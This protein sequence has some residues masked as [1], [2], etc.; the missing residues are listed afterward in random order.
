[1]IIRQGMCLNNTYTLIEEI[2]SGGGGIVYKAYHERL[3]TYVVVKR[4]KKQ[5]KGVL[6]NRAE[7][8]ILKNIKHTYLP[9]VYDFLQLD[10][11]IYT[12]MDYIPGRS[13]DKVLAETRAFPQK[14]A[15]KWMTQ[16]AEALAYLHARKPPVI[17]S[18]IKPAN[19][20]LTPEGNVCL[21]DFNVSLVFDHSIRTSTGI[22]GGYSPPEQYPDF[23]EYQKRA[24]SNGQAGWGA[25]FGMSG[26]G[27]AGNG[28]FPGQYLSDMEKTVVQIVGRGVDER[29]DI[30]SLGATFYHLMTGIKPNRDFSRLIPIDRYNLP[31]GEG[32]THILKKM[33]EI[34][35][36]ER[37]QN[38]GQLLY[39][40]QHIYEL[41]AEYQGYRSMRRG[42][43]TGA[44]IL[45][46]SGILALGGGWLIR[47]RE[48]DAAYNQKVEQAKELVEEKE[49]ER[50]QEFLAQ[51]M[52]IRPEQVAA[53]ECEVFRRYRQGDY[54]EC[55]RYGTAILKNSSYHVDSESDRSLLGNIYYMLGNCYLEEEDYP[56]AEMYLKT[57]IRQYGDNS[58]YHRDYAIAL[59]KQAR[60]DEAETM[61]E[62]AVSLGLGEDSIYMVQGEIAYAKGEYE[63]AEEYLSGAIA[64]TADDM[65]RR[66]AV[67]LGD[68]A[69]RELG[70]EWLDVEIG[71]LE[72]EENRAGG[73]GS[74]MYISER[75]AD[76][77]VR[78]AEADEGTG[79]EYYGK[80]LERFELL[81]QNGYATR[82]MMENI[83][84]LYEQMGDYENAKLMLTQMVEKYPDDYVGYKR[85]AY[86][87]ADIQQNRDNSERDYHL[88]V[89]Y[90]G[91]ARELYEGR[92]DDQEMDMMDA[93]M[94]DLRDGN[95]LQ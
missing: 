49:Y 94:Q 44:A 9:R 14:I 27:T 6:D 38:G 2:G 51:A 71:F 79:R 25:A 62:R 46:I 29:S 92:E 78:K 45:C 73:A 35:P 57:A 59:A 11:E 60:V 76:A 86:L 7:A 61:L 83:A 50:A 72:Q 89:E 32:I 53:Y 22:S 55:I 34:W 10:G 20:M 43:K 88:F 67:L 40:L 65:L 95:W 24:L 15:L 41:D 80:A 64:A 93:M 84:I 47:Q 26:P 19:I 12:V 90:Y 33:M 4:I 81:Y 18:D 52:Q 82:Q 63:T 91:R 77:Y 30:Y 1:M 75:L 42:L 5:V 28:M 70:S 23:Y 17:H 69:Y 74:A 3:R 87:E 21:I 37:Y 54:E 85:L 58:L 68:K 56:N 31:L 8:D 48:K 39:A 36:E 16:L 66:R 13:M